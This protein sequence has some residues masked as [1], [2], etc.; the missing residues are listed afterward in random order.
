M[1]KDQLSGYTIAKRH[2]EVLTARKTTHNTIFVSV[3]KYFFSRNY[4]LA[5]VTILVAAIS[6]ECMEKQENK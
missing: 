2:H 1:S 3:E 5:T 4:F 6:S